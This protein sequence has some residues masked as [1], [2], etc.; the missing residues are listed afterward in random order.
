V[1]QAH[2]NSHSKIKATILALTNEPVN[3]TESIYASIVWY[4]NNL[5][6]GPTNRSDDA[7]GP[8]EEKLFQEQSTDW[9]TK[10]QEMQGTEPSTALKL[11]F[12]LRE[13]SNVKWVKN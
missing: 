3:A 12:E 2:V 10:F 11:F 5:V 8:I 6:L 4:K 1:I 13:T 7:H 9:Q